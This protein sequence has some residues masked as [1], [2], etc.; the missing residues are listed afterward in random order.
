M[1]EKNDRTGS[2]AVAEPT[3]IGATVEAMVGNMTTV[4][5]EPASC[6]SDTAPT[7]NLW[8]S[9]LERLQGTL[10]EHSYNN[11]FKRATGLHHWENG[12]LTI[13]VPSEFY[14]GWLKD[15][16]LDVIRNAASETLGD[17]F[18]SVDFA[19][20]PDIQQEIPSQDTTEAA[21]PRSPGRRK[22][23]SLPSGYEGKTLASFVV[24]A[25]NRM[26]HASVQSLAVDGNLGYNPLYLCG[27][28]GLGKTHLLAAAYTEFK[29]QGKRAFYFPAERFIN[30][31]MECFAE[32][33]KTTH[34]IGQMRK[35]LLAV[36]ALLID[37]LDILNEGNKVACRR[38][39]LSVIN[40]FLAKRNKILIVAANNAPR[41]MENLGEALQSR[42]AKGLVVK[43]ESPNPETRISIMRQLAGKEQVPP[44]VL[45]HFAKS[46]NG[47][48]RLTEG[49]I[50][51]YLAYLKL[52]GATP[53]L[54]L[55]RQV[56]SLF[57]KE[58][59]AS[60]VTIEK[61][62]SIVA[63]HMG[64]TVADMKSPSKERRVSW[65][66]Q[67][68]I[69]FCHV[70]MPEMPLE[71]IGNAF[72]RRDHTTI[73]YACNAVKKRIAQYGDIELRDIQASITNS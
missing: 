12:V 6:Q 5:A 7:V 30:R 71:A 69:Y 73:I 50:T 8:Q 58:Q 60:P 27:S 67:V 46:L 72:G 62:Q 24:G 66:R 22:A 40:D 63:S 9:F 21:T 57:S 29:K 51:T 26:A 37:E 33:K 48:V 53:S 44:E 11:W 61:I 43:L 14:A 13:A 41:D 17:D 32:P 47:N 64:T 34:L 42:L 23:P 59:Q 49:A 70:L 38:E 4:N 16:F 1:F 35:S 19:I 25:G 39:F 31:L 54:E 20:N 68:A 10:D 3:A 36:D 52:D 2:T 65:P 15:H 56:L 28:S 18:H 55:A 45:D